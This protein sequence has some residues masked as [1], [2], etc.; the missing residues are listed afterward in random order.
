[1]SDQHVNANRIWYTRN[2][3]EAIATHL[4]LQLDDDGKPVTDHAAGTSRERSAHDA[5][6]GPGAGFRGAL[7]EL[8][9][10]YERESVFP[11]E[12]HGPAKELRALLVAHPAP[13][14]DATHHPLNPDCPEPGCRDSGTHGHVG[15]YTVPWQTAPVSDTRREDVARAIDPDAFLDLSDAHDPRTGPEQRYW[16]D[17]ALAGAD[18]IL[19]L[20][21]APPMV[22]EAEIA[23]LLRA[24]VAAPADALEARIGLKNGC[25][26]PEPGSSVDH[27]AAAMAARLRGAD[28]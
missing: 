2:A 28:R 23:A 18:R 1:M 9:E 20:R 22:D 3:V 27:Q 4:G 17:R 26:C 11:E 6:S 15:G 14:T 7:V 12:A 21:P 5:G 19:A 24:H 25:T 8:A 13:E 10:H 16:R